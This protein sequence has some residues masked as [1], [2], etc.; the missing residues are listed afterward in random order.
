MITGAPDV[1]AG[2]VISLRI[3]GDGRTVGAALAA[4]VVR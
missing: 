3:A 2:E 1:A 4:V